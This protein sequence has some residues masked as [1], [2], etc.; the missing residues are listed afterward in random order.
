M[1]IGYNSVRITLLPQGSQI[2]LQILLFS[3][4]VFLCLYWEI[5]LRVV[6]S[7]ILLIKDLGRPER[8]ML[9]FCSLPSLQ[10]VLCSEILPEYSYCT[11]R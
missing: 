11:L 3:S 8:R 9:L 4:S 6:V 7:S 5:F 1:G 10:G 2:E